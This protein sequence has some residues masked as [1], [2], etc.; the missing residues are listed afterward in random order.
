MVCT[1]ACGSF[2]SGT[3]VL[4]ARVWRKTSEVNLRCGSQGHKVLLELQYVGIT[5]T[6]CQELVEELHEKVTCHKNDKP[7]GEHTGAWQAGWERRDASAYHTGTT[8]RYFDL[9]KAEAPALA[10]DTSVHPQVYSAIGVV[11]IENL[12]STYFPAPT[13]ATLVDVS[14]AA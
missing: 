11:K 12:V 10:K 8:Q 9:S 13:S 2:S 4:S 1:L 3:P 14:A 7:W 5:Q 6:R